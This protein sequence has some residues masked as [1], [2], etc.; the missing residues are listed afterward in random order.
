MTP[1]L[2]V[3]ANVDLSGTSKLATKLVKNCSFVAMLVLSAW[4]TTVPGEVHLV[5]AGP[6]VSGVSDDPEGTEVLADCREQ[7]RRLPNTMRRRVLGEFLGD[8][9]LDQ[10]VDLCASLVGGAP[11]T[12]P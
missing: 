9:H 2:I 1:P 6:D 11:P 4:L 8:R 5:L 7:W 3:G 10:Y 12:G